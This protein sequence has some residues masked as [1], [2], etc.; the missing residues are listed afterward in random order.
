MA[1]RWTV[2]HFN[3]PV[4]MHTIPT[5]IATAAILIAATAFVRVVPVA[6]PADESADAAPEGTRQARRFII[7]LRPAQEA[8]EWL[9]GRGKRA[10][11]EEMNATAYYLE[12]M[13]QFAEDV[14]EGRRTVDQ[15]QRALM[16]ARYQSVRLRS[17]C[18]Q[19]FRAHVYADMARVWVDD[20]W[21]A[22]LA[23]YHAGR[24]VG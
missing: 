6:A 17:E 9:R 14:L 12:W 23:A 18:A 15:A 13:R 11:R 1:I 8:W 2:T 3:S 22:R 7:D 4:P 16:D 5:Y 21:P 19:Q 24:H 10:M 20:Q